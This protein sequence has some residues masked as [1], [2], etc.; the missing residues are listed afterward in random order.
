MFWLLLGGAL[1][2]PVLLSLEHLQ[3]P[4]STLN[5]FVGAMGLVVIV[6]GLRAAFRSA[7]VWWLLVVLVLGLVF[8]RASWFGLIQFSGAGFTQDFFIHADWQSV[9]IAWEEHGRLVRRGLGL[10]LLV[11]LLLAFGQR[12]FRA[13][14]AGFALMLL[15]MGLVMVLS[16]RQAMPEYELLNGWLDWRKPITAEVDVELLARFS[17]LGLIDEQVLPK[18]RV[19]AELPDRPKNLVLLYLESVGVNLAYQ[20]QWPE[21]MPN[22]GRLLD[23]HAW[24]DHIWTSSYIT[25]EGLTNTMCGTLLP[26]RQ[27]SD[28]LAEGEGLANDLPCLGDVL[29]RAGYHQVYL[30]GAGMSFAGKGDFLSTHGYDELKGLEYW[31]S[32]G[33]DQRPGTWGLSDADL[34]EQSIAEMHR[35]RERDQ[36]WNLTLLTIGTHLPGYLYQECH[37][38]PHAED[39]FLDALH[40]TDQ[41]MAQWLDRMQ[42]EGLLEDAVVVIT[43]DHHVFPSPD[44]RSLFGDDVLDRRLPLIVLGE[45]LPS[46]ADVVGAGYDLAPTVL[47]LLGIRHNAR[48]LLGRS[49]TRPSQRPDYFIKRYADIHDGQ[50]VRDEALACQDPVPGGL[51][52]PLD[53]CTRQEFLSMLEAMVMALSASASRVTCNSS[54]TN[55]LHLPEQIDEPL[56]VVVD[57]VDQAGR[58]TFQSRTVPS[59]RAGIYQLIFDEQG[60]ILARRFQPLDRLESWTLDWLGEDAV[61]HVL[62]WRPQAGAAGVAALPSAD[63]SLAL[64]AVPTLW[65][66]DAQGNWHEQAGSDEIDGVRIDLEDWFCKAF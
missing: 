48:F 57:D 43:S 42:E 61:S 14:P 44:M 56:E 18:H 52:L 28:S 5:A 39:V 33:L 32:I 35:L 22:F 31:R 63:G 64:P 62:A 4:P 66:V 7:P 16:A 49:L 38:Y 27:G 55:Y 8:L 40:C 47:D 46:A 59:N 60:S 29:N 54:T 17:A 1:V 24:V 26:F 65:F 45:D 37:A 30:G 21:L 11:A 23:E 6:M 19:Q 10:L 58:F 41:L 13:P 12:L 2:L 15:P 53:S 36:P 25:I 51:V 3:H 50:R 9:V 20:P 34:F